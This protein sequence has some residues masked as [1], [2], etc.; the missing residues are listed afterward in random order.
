MAPRNPCDAV[1]PPRAARPEIRPLTSEQVMKL[2]ET[3]RVDRFHALDVLAV[4][5]GMRQGELLGLQW[6][7]VDLA[8]SALQVR[9]QLHELDGRLR[10]DIPRFAHFPDEGRP[11]PRSRRSGGNPGDTEEWLMHVS[12]GGS[13]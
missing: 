2:L 6:A 11:A 13:W 4:A 7:D 5:T 12:A 3:T 8:A 10:R 9:H 1:T